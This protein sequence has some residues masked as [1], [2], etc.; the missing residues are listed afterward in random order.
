MS[1]SLFVLR[2]ET[3]AEDARERIYEALN[4]GKRFSNQQLSQTTLVDWERTSYLSNTVSRK[5]KFGFT[6][7]FKIIYK[8]LLSENKKT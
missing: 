3:C 2:E 5:K 6:K 8:K 1:Y 4:G 7:H